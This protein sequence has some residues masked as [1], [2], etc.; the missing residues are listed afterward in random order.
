MSIDSHTLS[1]S[2]R[3]KLLDLIINLEEEKKNAS[4]QTQTTK[5]HSGCFIQELPGELPSRKEITWRTE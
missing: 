1:T 3:V 2:K 4:A 5:T